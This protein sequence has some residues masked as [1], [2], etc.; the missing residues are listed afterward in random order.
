MPTYTDYPVLTPFQQAWQQQQYQ[1][2][3][4]AWQQ[5]TAA[6]TS[7]QYQYTTIRTT[8]T[9][10][11]YYIIDTFT[12]G[13]DYVGTNGYG[14]TGGN[15]YIVWQQ[16]Q[17]FEIVPPTPEQLDQVRRQQEAWAE[18]QRV[19]QEELAAAE[20]KAQELIADIL[21][22]DAKQQLQ[23]CGYIDVPVT[24]GRFA[25][26]VTAHNVEGRRARF[27]GAFRFYRIRANSGICLVDR[28]GKESGYLCIHSAHPDGVLPPSDDLLTKWWTA[29]MDE[30]RLW[31]IGNYSRRMAVAAR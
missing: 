23:E 31:V 18:R 15:G 16:P 12:N 25:D 8:N 4:V 3:Q 20:R 6:M 11:N 7:V 29:K 22:A 30:E 2:Y 9:T 21:D 26:L 13:N 10:S 28:E 1:Q 27:Q 17:S 14:A 5:Q 19:A 24:R